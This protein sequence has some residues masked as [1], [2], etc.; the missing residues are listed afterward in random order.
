M[1]FTKHTIMAPTAVSKKRRVEDAMSG[2][3]AKPRKKIRKQREYHSDSSEDEPEAEA[4][5]QLPKPVKKLAKKSE[6]VPKNTNEASPEASDSLS[7]DGSSS[8][9]T[10]NESSEQSD[11]DAPQSDADSDAEHQ[12]PR[13]KVPKRNDPSAFSTSMSKILSTKLPTS[14]RA[15]PLLS[16]S[17]DASQAATHANNERLENHVRAKLRAERKEVMEKGR[18]KDVLG[19]ES[20][21]AGETADLEKRLRKVAQRGVIKM[22]NAVRQA[23]VRGEQMAQEERTARVTVGMGE[24]EKHVNEI[25]KQGFLELINGK[26]GKKLNIEEA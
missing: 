13:K 18:I 25:S 8:E 21:Q 6:K 17:K 3:T 15:D 9:A 1:Q 19:V 22:F 24:R 16:R 11:S 10:N 5:Q 4:P 2:K 12:P 23:Q 7:D 26:G 20:G 14:A